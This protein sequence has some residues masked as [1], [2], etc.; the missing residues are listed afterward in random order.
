[1]ERKD[2]KKKKK[3]KKENDVT[4]K[5]ALIDTRFCLHS[6]HSFYA[7]PYV[8]NLAYQEVEREGLNTL[9]FK[10]KEEKKHYKPNNND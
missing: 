2:N 9:T 6:G 7:S 5:V 4:K 3:K 8:Y 10:K 1:M